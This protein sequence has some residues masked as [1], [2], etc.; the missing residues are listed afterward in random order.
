[1]QVI[2]YFFYVRN[3]GEKSVAY[4]KK[5]PP[6]SFCKEGALKNFANLTGKHLCCSFF[7]IKLQ[8]QG[9]AAF[10]KRDSNTGVFLVNF[11]KLI[12]KKYL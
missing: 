7:S 11:P 12:R 4:I 1:M 5:Q 10:L 2:R 9:P 6:E 8:T 3:I